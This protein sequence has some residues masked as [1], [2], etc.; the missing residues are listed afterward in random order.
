MRYVCG[1]VIVICFFSLDCSVCNVKPIYSTLVLTMKF[2][3]GTPLSNCGIAAIDGSSGCVYPS[4][5]KAGEDCRI[6]AVC[7]VKDCRGVDE[8][9]TRAVYHAVCDT[10]SAGFDTDKPFDREVF[11]EALHSAGDVLDSVGVV[12]GSNA[13]DGGLCGGDVS[14]AV[15]L[16]H[17]GG[18]FVASTGGAQV[19]LV[20]PGQGIMYRSHEVRERSSLGNVGK[21]HFSDVSPKNLTDLRPGDYIYLSKGRAG[22]MADDDITGLLGDG[23]IGDE[24]KLQRLA[25]ATV[26]GCG[27]CE[28]LV[29]ITDVQHDDEVAA[30]DGGSHLVAKRRVAASHGGAWHAFIVVGIFVSLLAL[31]AV[32]SYVIDRLGQ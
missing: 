3:I 5:D 30:S 15:A 23:A 9:A 25:Y 26:G 4:P 27:R 28:C 7:D 19:M 18:C 20:R 13:P 1:C 31:F 16:L 32:V 6:F 17:R 24:E 29:H 14:L 22:I 10:M 11:E 12:D 2:K 21:A 8:V